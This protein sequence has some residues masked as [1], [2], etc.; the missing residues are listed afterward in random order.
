MQVVPEPHRPST[1]GPGAR[2]LPATPPPIRSDDALEDEIDFSRYF[3][4]F[5]R[6]WMLLVLATLVGA[7]AGFSFSRTKPVLY[8]GVTTVL[9][10]PPP[11]TDVRTAS[12]A[13]FRAL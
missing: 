3:R 11:K 9:V 12:T 6:H 5:A 2:D 8:E 13:N 4:I 7:A 1:V 10:L